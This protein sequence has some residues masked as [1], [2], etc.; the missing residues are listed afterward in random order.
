MIEENNTSPYIV[1]PLLPRI[2]SLTPDNAPK[3]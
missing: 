1:I 3:E 2:V